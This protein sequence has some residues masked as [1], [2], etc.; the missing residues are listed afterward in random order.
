M[1]D[2]KGNWCI[3]STIIRRSLI[4]ETAGQQF[5][6]PSAL[7]LGKANRFS[8]MVWW[9]MIDYWSKS[10]KLITVDNFLAIQCIYV[11]DHHFHSILD[12]SVT[13]SLCFN[14]K[15]D[16]GLPSSKLTY[17]VAILKSTTNVNEFPIAK[18]MCRF[19]ASQLVIVYRTVS[20]SLFF[21]NRKPQEKLRTCRQGLSNLSY[22]K[23]W[24]TAPLRGRNLVLGFR[25]AF[26]RCQLWRCSAASGSGVS[27]NAN[28]WMCCRRRYTGI[29]S[30][31]TAKTPENTPGP[32]RKHCCFQGG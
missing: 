1:E 2:L 18:K 29:P 13:M 9:L 30:L 10:N 16:M 20:S 27:G 3:L 21:P 26:V 4:Q 28:G 14:H 11:F 23:C 8:C 15:V 6:V 12:Y 25:I 19:P 7:E 24:E 5:T 22:G 32:K 17:R 31:K